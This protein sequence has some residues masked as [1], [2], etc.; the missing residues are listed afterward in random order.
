[1]VITPEQCAAGILNNA[2][3]G[4]CFGGAAH[5]ATAMMTSIMLGLV[6][7]NVVFTVADKVGG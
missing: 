6:P 4:H 2:T 7:T 3:S 1:M 5:E